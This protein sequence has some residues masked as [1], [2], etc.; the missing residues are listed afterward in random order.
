MNELRVG[1]LPHFQILSPD[2]IPAL[3]STPASVLDV[4]KTAFRVFQEFQILLYAFAPKQPLNIPRPMH[5]PEH[6]YTLFK[7]AIEDQNTFKCGHPKHTEASEIKM[8]KAQSP[9]HLR[10]R[11]QKCKRVVRCHQK[12][13]A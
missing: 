2:D 13:V 10:L 8:P 3:S 11:D 4:R 7:R 1:R 9:S 5:D 6:L 12:P